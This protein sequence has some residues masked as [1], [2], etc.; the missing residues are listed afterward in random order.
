M[1]QIQVRLIWHA[2]QARGFVLVS[3][4]GPTA[5]LRG[6]SKPVN[7]LRAA[8][9]QPGERFRRAVVLVLIDDA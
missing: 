6:G 7:L 8:G 3:R 9:R 4:A 1:I 5:L 2:R